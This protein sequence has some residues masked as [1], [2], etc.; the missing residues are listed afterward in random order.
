MNYLIRLSQSHTDFRLAELHALAELSHTPITIL[1]YTPASPIL[2]LTA[3]S[4]EAASALMDRAILAQSIHEHWGSGP[5]LDA[6]HASVKA[7]SAHLWPTH[8][9]AS[10]KFAIDAF[11]GGG[12]A[13]RSPAQRTALIN[14]FRYLPLAGPINLT[15]PDLHL[16]IFEEYAPHAPEPHTYHL[17]RLLARS[18]ALPAR[19]DLKQ[20]PY[21]STTSMA[22]DLALLTANLALAAPGKL[23][24]DP[25]AGTGSF[26][27]ASAAFGAVAWGSDI[28]GRAVRATGHDARHA[29]GRAGVRGERSVRG[30]FAFYGLEA[31]LGDVFTCDLTN[32]PLRRVGF[33]EE[34]EGAGA[35][36]R[37]ARRL[38]DGIVCDPPYG[39]REGLRVLGCKDP[40]GMPW[41]VEAGVKKYK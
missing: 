30:N 16:T 38:F 7:T 1:S 26:P 10:W 39:V 41:V 12:S 3:P 34:G 32:S 13:A 22:A 15:H 9:H 4:P 35:A 6:L 2:L 24:Y 27:L 18:P 19:F 31:R 36:G 5:T 37:P 33:N 14:T 17:G 20:R 28:D 29:A 25:F 23:F 8:A 21:I 11:Q 40:E